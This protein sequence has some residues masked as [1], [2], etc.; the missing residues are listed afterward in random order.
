MNSKFLSLVGSIVG[1]T[2]LVGLVT[3]IFNIP[4]PFAT[5]IDQAYGPCAAIVFGWLMIIPQAYHAIPWKGYITLLVIYLLTFLGIAVLLSGDSPWSI[6]TLYTGLGALGFAARSPRILVDSNT[7]SCAADT[8]F[9][10][11]ALLILIL[12]YS[13]LAGQT[14]TVGIIGSGFAKVFATLA[15]LAKGWEVVQDIAEFTLNNLQVEYYIYVVASLF[16]LASAKSASTRF[17]PQRFAA[18]ILTILGIATLLV[19]LYMMFF[20]PIGNISI[21]FL[22]LCVCG[23]GVALSYLGMRRAS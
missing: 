7:N 14:M 8:L 2:G 4:L 22:R 9:G 3:M 6:I 1:I 18:Y 5:R 17:V 19:G 10:V 15:D 23:F 12:A 21:L 20:K 16:W 11:T 13:T